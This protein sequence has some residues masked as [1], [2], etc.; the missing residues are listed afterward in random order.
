MRRTTL[1]P[2][3][4]AARISRAHSIRPC[5]EVLEDRLVPTID[6]LNLLPGYAVPGVELLSSAAV[7]ING[8]PGQPAGFSPQQ[9]S[10]AYGFNQIYFE[11]GAIKGDGSGQTIAIVDAYNQPHIASDLQTFDA[12]YGLPAPP[13]FTVVNENGGSSLPA[14]D[15]GWGLEISLDVEW[16][17]AMAPG[18]N[19]VLVEANS[20]SYSD[21]MAAVNYARN[22]SGVSVVSM[23]WGSGEWYGESGYDSYFTTPAGHQ[24]VTFVASSGDAGSGGA[25]EYPSVSPNVLAVGGTQLTT[26]SAGNYLSEVGWSGSGGGI[27][28]TESQPSYQQ[29]VVTQT[30]TYRTVPD[31]SYNGSSNSPFAVYDTSSYGGWIEVYGTSAGAPQW[32]ALVAIADQGRALQ[33]QGSLDGGSQTL[34]AIYQLPQSDFHDITSGSNGGYSAGPGYDLVTG[35][36]SPLANLV[37]SG[38]V[39]YGTSATAPWVSTPAYAAPGTVSGTSTNLSVAGGD[40]Y[41]TSALTYTWSVISEPAGAADPTFS[42]N[43]TNAAQNTTVT[44]HAAGT[45]VFQVTI[46]NIYG[47]STTSDVTVTVNQTLSGISLTPVGASVYN[48][49]LLQ[50]TATAIDQFGQ[51][52][53]VQPAWG[54]S[55]AGPGLLTGEGLYIAP[56]AGSGAATIYVIGDGLSQAV[57]VR[58]TVSPSSPFPDPGQTWATWL[59]ILDA[60]LSQFSQYQSMWELLL[61]TWSVQ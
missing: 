50:F 28:F 58:F 29:G 8:S 36:G 38:L 20:P 2:G 4:R 41:N 57:T 54:W 34:P 14:S 19:I 27:S 13:S 1:S 5:L 55:L 44:F 6:L 21:L 35:R 11:N 24:G 48:G 42:V 40:N 32:A 56:S 25:P 45:Y 51:S 33:G 53:S 15:Q 46:T 18:A 22:L 10:Q 23:S 52:M 61:A 59:Q 12:T 31:V 3:L 30:G 49:N 37:V 60:W 26:D 47:L 39:A 7:T 16:A 9:I 43:G 17:H